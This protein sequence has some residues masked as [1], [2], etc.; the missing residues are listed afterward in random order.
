MLSHKGLILSKGMLVWV[1][2][3]MCIS[4]SLPRYEF[5]EVRQLGRYT[6]NNAIEL[7]NEKIYAGYEGTLEVVTAYRLKHI[8]FKSEI[9]K[10]EMRKSA[11]SA[12]S[13]RWASGE[14]EEAMQRLILRI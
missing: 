13:K 4:K 14:I 6:G 1:P 10:E 2:F 11:L 12:L 9:E 8:V 7:T 3:V 5:L